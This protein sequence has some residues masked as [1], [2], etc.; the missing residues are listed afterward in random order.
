MKK[1]RKEFL[2]GV[3]LL[4]IFVIYT[5]S[6][7]FIDVRAI[8]PKGSLVGYGLVNNFIHKLFG[9]HLKIY[10]ITDWLGIIVIFIAIGFGF[11]GLFQLT[12]RKSIFKVDF[13][14]LL[15]GI[16]YL[17]VFGVYLFFEFKV[18]NYRP[19][20]INGKLEASYPSSTTMLSMCII[21]TAIIELN[22]LINDKKIKKIIKY[23]CLIFMVFMVIGRLISG[24]HWFTDIFGGFLFSL[25]MVL[26]YNSII[27]FID[28][29]RGKKLWR[30]FWLLM[31][32]LIL[33]I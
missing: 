8:G 19:I 24:V 28:E 4:I 17:L 6:L 29:N 18:I 27:K 5:I 10:N 12:K 26:I 2:M 22:R 25:S 30:Q 31:M 23:I 16:F 32:I 20:L 13:S 3:I 21:P 33:E 11:L 14:I 9:V 7:K 15:L 1:T